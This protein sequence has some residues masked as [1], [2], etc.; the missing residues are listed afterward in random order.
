MPSVSRTQQRLMG[1]AHAVR[2]FMDTRGKEGLDPDDIDPKYK[3]SIV[4]IAKGMKKKSLKHYA[5]TKHK[6]LPEEVE[7]DK[8]PGIYSYLDPEA[9]EPKKRTESSKMQNLADYREFVKKYCKL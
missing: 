3:D 5:E 2:K 6:K 1:Q 9:N 7:E 8:I 4:G